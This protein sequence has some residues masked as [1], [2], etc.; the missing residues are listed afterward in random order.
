MIRKSEKRGKTK[1]MLTRKFA[2][3][4]LMLLCLSDVE[5]EACLPASISQWK[6]GYASVNIL[7]VV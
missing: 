2:V 3:L 1:A 5:A 4:F 7:V 6:S